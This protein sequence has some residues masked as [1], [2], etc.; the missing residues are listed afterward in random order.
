MASMPNNKDT[1]KMDSAARR[2]AMSEAP[3]P[4]FQSNEEEKS[5]KAAATANGTVAA[6]GK[7]T[8]SSDPA[9]NA[10]SATN[11]T[12]E[13]DAKPQVHDKT[14][15]ECS[16]NNEHYPNVVMD[17]VYNSTLEK[18]YNIIFDSEFMK[19]FLVDNQKSTG[20]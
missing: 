19:K 8:K 11:T 4:N 15:C 10:A 14:D 6:N 17:Q 3:R 2:R 7:S 13:G 5:S 18:I 12:K 20:K 9:A 16:T 1:A